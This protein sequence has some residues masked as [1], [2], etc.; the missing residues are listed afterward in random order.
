MNLAALSLAQRN[1]LFFTTPAL[2]PHWPML[3]LVRRREGCAP[4]LGL[5]YDAAR[6]SG[7]TGYSATVFLCNLLLLPPTEE[8]FLALPKEVFDTAEEI[9]AAGWSVD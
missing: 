6:K 7:H 2:W 3:P 1:L 5:L 9:A 4:E 8:E